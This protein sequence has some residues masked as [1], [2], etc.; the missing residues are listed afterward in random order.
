MMKN[1]RDYVGYQYELAELQGKINNWSTVYDDDYGVDMDDFYTGAF[2]RIASRYG[3]N[4]YSVDWQDEAFGGHATTQ[5]HNVSISTGTEKTRVLLSYNHVD[6]DGLLANHDYRRN[7]LRAKI[8]AELWKGVKIDFNSFFYDNLT[9]G[10]GNYGHMDY[11]LLQPINGGTLFT[12]DELMNSE[13]SI[14]FKSSTLS[15]TLTTRLSRILHLFH[16]TTPNAL[17]PTP[18]SPLT[19]SNISHGVHRATI[20]PHG[21]KAHLLPMN[22]LPAIS[23]IPKTPECRAL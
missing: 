10:G 5:N 1:V 11:V 23:Q 12:Q 13:T 17:K 14:Q 21:A 3:N 4:P 20:P 19:S 16:Q 18:A 15:I 8:N 7:S 2:D 22:A 9:H 6:Q